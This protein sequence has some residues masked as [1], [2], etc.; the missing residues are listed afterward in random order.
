[1]RQIDYLRVENKI[2]R[3]KL[4]KRVYVTPEEKRRLVKFAIP[5]GASI[6]DFASI[7]GYTTFRKWI[8]GGV[9]VG[10]KYAKRGRKRTPEE[11]REL[12]VKLAKENDWGYT[13]IIGELKKLGIKSISRSTV[14]RILKENGLDPAPK[15]YASYCTSLVRFDS[16]S[17]NSCPLPTM[18][19]CRNLAINSLFGRSYNRSFLS[20]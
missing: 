19:F 17:I 6:K 11:I 1:M 18:V 16:N 3:G 10:R 12:V 2:L 20:L 13:R 4:G 15:G 5:L 9:P 8:T 14:R 7:V